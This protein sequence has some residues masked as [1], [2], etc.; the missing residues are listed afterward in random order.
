MEFF[1][2]SR[3]GDWNLAIVAL[4]QFKNQTLAYVVRGQGESR[5]LNLSIHTT[6]EWNF[7]F[8]HSKVLWLL[9]C[10]YCRLRGLAPLLKYT[11]MT[12]C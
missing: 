5:M 8:V 10:I 1:E 9:V 7:R 6:S 3:N 4:T 2:K 11:D 12:S